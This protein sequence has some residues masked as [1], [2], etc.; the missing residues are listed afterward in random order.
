MKCCI[1]AWH[2]CNVM[3]V[4]TMINGT[5]TQKTWEGCLGLAIRLSQ[6]FGFRT[7]Q[8]HQCKHKQPSDNLMGGC[9]WLQAPARK[10]LLSCLCPTPLS[11]P[12]M[13]IFRLSLNR[14]L[15][16]PLLLFWEHVVLV[17]TCQRALDKGYFWQSMVATD[18]CLFFL[19]QIYEFNSTISKLLGKRVVFILFPPW[20]CYFLARC[21]MV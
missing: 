7:L 6:V 18:G 8:K 15:L 21:L 12:E 11:L 13:N 16:S 2:S 14:M 17:M 10:F 9:H 1:L 5:A 4:A 20:S 19:T 3:I